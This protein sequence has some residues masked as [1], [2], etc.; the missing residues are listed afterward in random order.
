M[1]NSTPLISV[2]LPVYNVAS[3]INEA[4]DSILKQTIQD[5][6]ILVIDDCSTDNTISIIEAIKDSRIKIIR[7]EKNKGLIDSLN[8]GFKIAQGKYIARMDGD[9]I[10]YPNRFEEQIS[11]LEDNSQYILC[12]SWAK[13]IGFD[14]VMKVKE[15]HDE[16]VT[17]FLLTNSI[18]HP[19]VMIR[20]KSLEKFEFDQSMIAVED[21]DYWT[22]LCFEGKFYNIP[23]PLLLYRI[24]DNQVSTKYKD[25]QIKGDIKIRMNLYKKLM[26][27]ETIYK[28]SILIKIL[29]SNN[30]FNKNEFELLLK[31]FNELSIKNKKIKLFN[32]YFF[33]KTSNK[34]IRNLV[35]NVF[36]TNQKKNINQKD[37][38][39]IFKLLPVNEKL[40]VL[41]L[42]IK[43]KIKY[44]SKSKV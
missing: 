7:K 25:I 42:K 27:D 28:D 9:D 23:K 6:E 22:K 1:N 36:F 19:T 38:I 35:F 17:D 16:I 4:I 34:I 8:F 5:Y 39:Q 40:F 43:E 15:K 24:H 29:Y 3:Y 2:I 11:F 13:V 37:R 30:Y 32:D 26:Y 21:Y 10:C 41:R 14:S 31:W 18:I 12:G 20:N 44:L 33:E